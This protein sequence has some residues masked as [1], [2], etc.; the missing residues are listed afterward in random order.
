MSRTVV[1]LHDSTYFGGAERS[2]CDLA[3]G[4][5]ERGH[6]V[7][8]WNAGA[9]AELERRLDALGL[10]RR[11]LPAPDY[12]TRDVLGF[13]RL[14]LVLAS[15]WLRHRPDLVHANGITSCKYA[16]PAAR[17]LH[18][19]IVGHVRDVPRLDRLT[20]A[21]LRRADLLLAISEFIAEPLRSIP[22]ARCR[23]LLNAIDVVGVRPRSGLARDDGPLRVVTPAAF[24]PNKR[25]EL[26]L[27]CARRLRDAGCDVR[28]KVCGPRP[29]PDYWERVRELHARLDLAALVSLEEAQDQDSVYRDADVVVSTAL[30]E[31]FGRTV[32]EGHAR[33]L[34]VVGFA[35]GALP[36]I[37]EHGRTGLLPEDGD[38]DAMVRAIRELD[39]DRSRAREMGRAGRALAERRFAIAG[40]LDELEAHHASLA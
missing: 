9:N 32:I 16:L 6:R 37:V 15:R 35:G 20:R 4:L 27:E 36:E 2:L 3:A 22:G 10:P 8:V 25:L 24:R 29:Y 38:V 30:D 19:P 13:A 7:E 14:S 33:G 12:G 17:L 5:A 1:F 28:W 40:L 34:P 39:G 26:V 11:P 21:L 23:V 18:L 31:P